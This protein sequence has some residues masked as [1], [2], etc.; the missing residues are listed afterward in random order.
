MRKQQSTTRAYWK[1]VVGAATIVMSASG[2]AAV[3][4]PFEPLSGKP[5]LAYG[6]YALEELGYSLREFTFEGTAVSYQPAAQAGL[7]G[8]WVV[9]PAGTAP[10]R[11]RLVAMMPKDP[12]KFNGTVVVEWMNVSGGLDVPVD[13]VTVHRELTRRGYGY[14]G[15]SA[16]KAGIDGGR[17]MVS[18]T[19]PLKL[20]A[21][22]RYGTLNHPGDAFSYDIFSQVGAA[23]R[24]G[25]ARAL[26]GSL[27]P[28]RLI[29]IGESQSAGRLAA[30]VNAVDPIARVYD[31][32]IVHS[33]G[34]GTAGL[35]DTPQP[36][37][38]AAGMMRA[39]RLR[40]DGR[41]KLM[42]VI[43]ETD[44]LALVSR[45]TRVI[46]C[47]KSPGPHTRTITCSRSE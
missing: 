4:A 30:Y 29:A 43:T 13:W 37:A 14:V 5:V 1:A 33:R 3:A 9:T 31:G 10:F 38:T 18:G 15:V 41:A 12:R 34:S 6:N 44:L 36:Q 47:G 7:D 42:E 39:A 24:Q 17:A 2:P 46:G 21:P 11:T 25:G 16:Q 8:R 27:T 28:R 26:L 23:L 20:A 40:T 22:A 32:I 45:T 35:S 19:M